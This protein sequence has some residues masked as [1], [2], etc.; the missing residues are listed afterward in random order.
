M[1]TFWHGKIQYTVRFRIEYPS[2]IL[3]RLMNMLDQNKCILEFGDNFV[4]I[5][6]IGTQA[7]LS[8]NYLI[9]HD[10]IFAYLVLVWKCGESK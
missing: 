3:I 4:L 2:M 10:L 6:L 1:E 7:G 5:K 9:K 8:N